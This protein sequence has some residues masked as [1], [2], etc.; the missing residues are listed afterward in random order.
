VAAPTGIG[1]TA[2]KVER[3]G[4][5]ADRRRALEGVHFAAVH[6]PGSGT[7]VIDQALHEARLAEARFPFDEQHRPVSLQQVVYTL[8]GQ[9]QL[10][11]RPTS[12]SVSP[13]ATARL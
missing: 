5:R 13:D 2:S 9:R 1:G 12:A 3:V 11:S 10:Q 8:P 6:N 4:D 7:R